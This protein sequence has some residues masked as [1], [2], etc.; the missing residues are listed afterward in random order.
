MSA[1]KPIIPTEEFAER[2]KKVQQAMAEEGLDVVVVYGDD[3]AAFGQQN[4][5][6]MIDYAPHFEAVCLAIPAEGTPQAATGA[7]ME[8]FLA[9]NSRLGDVI[10]IDE[11]C[12]PDEEY[13]YSKPVPFAKFVEKVEAQLGH[14]IRRVGV[15][16]R[17]WMPE[18]LVKAWEG[19]VPAGAIIS[20]DKRWYEIKSIKSPAEIAVIKYAYSLAE[21][22]LAA[23]V[24]AIA[25]GVTERE[26][27]AEIEYAMRKLGSEGTG[28]DTIV[29]S[30]AKNTRTILTRAYFREL[31]PNDLVVLTI[32]PRYEGYHAAIGRPYIVSGEPTPEM[33]HA[34]K[35]SVDAYDAIVEKLRAGAVAKDVVKAGLD[36]YEREGLLEHCVYSGNHSVGTAEFEPPILTSDSDLVLEENMVISVD[37]PMFFAE[38][39]GM[40]YEDGYLVTPGDPLKLNKT[41]TIPLGV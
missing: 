28:I 33:V 41:P 19:V 34:A 25:P 26:I 4:T 38:W 16:E 35:T 12:N 3:R 39:G 29:G 27:A 31:K 18:W 14:K 15:I 7:E 40:R 10:A 20:F 8:A 9:N 6:W 21:A 23:G 22:G 1:G 32:A 24:A 11:F 2:L 13:P 37:V 5:R 17:I 30:G 36:V